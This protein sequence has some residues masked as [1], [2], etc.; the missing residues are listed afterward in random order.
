MSNVDVDCESIAEIAEAFMLAK[1]G[2]PIF[3]CLTLYAMRQTVFDS[4][5]L[6]LLFSLD[7]AGAD[8]YLFINKHKKR[9]KAIGNSSSIVDQFRAEYLLVKYN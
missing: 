8:I 7:M 4:A 6:K 9:F 2:G 5:Y 3:K 1:I